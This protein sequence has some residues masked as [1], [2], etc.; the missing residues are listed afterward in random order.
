M[1]PL[2][3]A[4]LAL[5]SS[6][7]AVDAPQG[8]ANKLFKEQT[9]HDFGTV[10]R[11]AQLYHRFPVTNIYAVPL[12]FTNL[13]ISCGCLT[14]TA[15]PKVLQPRESGYIE[16]TMDARRF[17]G[18]KTVTVHVTVGPTFISTAELKVIGN[19]R[20][21]V[22]FNPGHVNFG[23]VS[24][25]HTEAHTIDVEYAGVLDWKVTELLTKDLP[26][27]ATFKELYRRPGQVGY[28][29]RVSL[30][31]DAPPGVLKRE[32]HLRTNDPASPL[33]AILVEADIQA[34]LT[35][36]PQVLRLGQ[37][38]VGDSLSRKVSIRSPKPLKVLGVDGLGDG[39]SLAA[40]PSTE[41]AA[42]QVLTFKCEIKKAGE[43]RKVL[44]IRT[45]QQSTPLTV[46]VEA[47]VGDN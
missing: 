32:L 34:T 31:P 33:I 39:V 44:Q 25:G 7:P 2:L 24:P 10:A 23:A 42:T 46:T 36:S 30:K 26:F 14:A 41:A 15:V 28:Q 43:F 21:D 1:R 19:S 12:E 37:L 6:A 8:W 5:L 4:L 17:N 22:V 18:P 11:G 38:Q 45:D 47:S 27:E 29:V 13:R 40:E 3:F 35:V 16:V 20:A 9:T